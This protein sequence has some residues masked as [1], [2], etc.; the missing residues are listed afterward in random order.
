MD[1]T[2]K[3]VIDDAVPAVYNIIVLYHAAQAGAKQEE[4]L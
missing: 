2:V 4:K 3:A 1:K